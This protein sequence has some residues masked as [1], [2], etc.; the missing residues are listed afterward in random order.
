MSKGCDQYENN[1][2]LGENLA[3]L[4]LHDNF[5]DTDSHMTPLLGTVNF[6]DVMKALLD[7]NYS[8]PF[9]FETKMFRA[10]YEWPNYTNKYSKTANAE[11]FLWV[12]D[13]VLVIDGLKLM[14]LVG[15]TVL[16]KYGI[17]A[18]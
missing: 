15:E 9:N 13:R 4:H 17:N 18:E 7:I 6:D 11:H 8:G 1:T 10:G 3:G 16:R 12:P 2:L 5:G 14:R